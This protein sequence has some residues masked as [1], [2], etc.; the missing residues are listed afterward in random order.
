MKKLKYSFRKSHESTNKK[1][2]KASIRMNSCPLCEF[3]Y[4]CYSA[5]IVKGLG[6]VLFKVII[7][8]V[9]SPIILLDTY[10]PSNQCIYQFILP[11]KEIA[12]SLHSIQYF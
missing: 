12:R 4:E 6:F 1:M 9:N 7:F 11:L 3:L 5:K 2:R 8:S 10:V